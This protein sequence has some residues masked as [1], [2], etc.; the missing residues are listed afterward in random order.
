[1]GK[2][3]DFNAGLDG[4]TNIVQRAFACQHHAGEAKAPGKIRAR[5]VAKRHLRAGMQRQRGEI[6]PYH[7]SHAQILYDHGV[8]ARAA[9]RVKRLAHG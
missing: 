2:H 9:N 3:L 4:S 5:G 8:C 6:P 7:G 1:M